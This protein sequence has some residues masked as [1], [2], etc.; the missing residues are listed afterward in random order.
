LTLSAPVRP[1][2]RRRRLQLFS[3]CF[4][5]SFLGFGA[6]TPQNKNI[7]SAAEK[8]DRTVNRT[9]AVGHASIETT[10]GYVEID[11]ASLS[12]GEKRMRNI[13]D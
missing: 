6:N 12:S 10:H 1:V 2:N 8:L 4:G 13:E 9:S 7:R 5:N 3:T 11:F